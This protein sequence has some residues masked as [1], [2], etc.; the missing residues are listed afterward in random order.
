MEFREWLYSEVD[1]EGEFSDVQKTC[2]DPDKLVEYL[3]AV[4]AN[5]KIDYGKREKFSP[6]MPFVHSKSSFFGKKDEVDFEDFARRITEPPKTIINTNEKIL[7]SGGPHEFVYKTGLPAFRGIVYDKASDKFYV[8]NTCPGAGA[9]VMI[10]YARRG[11]YIQYAEAYDSM[12]RRLNHLLN[13]PDQYEEQMY[14]EVRAKCEEHGAKIGYKPKVILRWND[15]GDFFTRK[16]KSIA[17][18]VLRRLKDEGWNVDSYAYTKVADV[19]NDAEFQ[20]TFSSGANMK[21]TAGVDFDKRKLSMVVPREI[22]SDLD[23]MKIDDEKELK[24]RI[25]KK[26]V[27]PISDILT[28]GEMMSLPKGETPRW[29]VVV[30]PGDGDDAA[31][32]KDVKTI[33]LTQH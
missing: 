5:A 11:R 24:A 7:R 18:G 22:F 27:L 25:A 23:L 30:T 26:F 6:N 13:H 16:Y 10:C 4:R 15:S 3:N 14:S 32:R 17:E 29:H 28:Y 20:T 21:Q 9:C 8:I 1:W 33:L 12:T 31:F 19:A 2:E